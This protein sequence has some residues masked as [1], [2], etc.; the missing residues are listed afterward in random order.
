MGLKSKQEEQTKGNKS[1]KENKV[2]IKEQKMVHL[3][4]KLKK[5]KEEQ[6][7]IELGLNQAETV[8]LERTNQV[9]SKS[10]SSSIRF[11]FHFTASKSDLK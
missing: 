10:W 9:K 2:F 1:G 4:H 5:L 7:G 8:S 6:A 11:C 3:N